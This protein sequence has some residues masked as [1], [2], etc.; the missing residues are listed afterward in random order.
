MQTNF[1][2]VLCCDVKS[3]TFNNKAYHTVLVYSVGHLY[4]LSVRDNAT[5]DVVRD[6]VGHYIN[7]HTDMSM[8]DGKAKFVVKSIEIL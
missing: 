8:F 5:L 7:A 6:A 1:D 3:G 2:N 4:S